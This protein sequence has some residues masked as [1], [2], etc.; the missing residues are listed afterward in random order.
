M[1]MASV[2][3]VGA[4]MMLLAILDMLLALE[5]ESVYFEPFDSYLELT[6]LQTIVLLYSL[7]HLI[8]I[9]VLLPSEYLNLFQFESTS[10]HS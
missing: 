10:P 6:L 1:K 4:L 9:F 7:C 8:V 3:A 5:V 2:E